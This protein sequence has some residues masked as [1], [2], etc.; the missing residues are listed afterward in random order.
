M[1][2]LQPLRW[3]GADLTPLPHESELSALLRFAWRN[4][5]RVTR[6]RALLNTKCQKATDSSVS[7]SGS[8]ENF[9]AITGWKLVEEHDGV[10]TPSHMIDGLWKHRSF[11]FCPLCLEAAYHS[12]WHQFRPLRYCPVHQ[13]ELRQ[14]CQCCSAKIGPYRISAKL[15]AKPYYCPLCGDP[16]SG[17]NRDIDAH[18][19]FRSHADEL[20]LAFEP[21]DAWLRASGGALTGIVLPVS[22]THRWNFWCRGEDFLRSFVTHF[23][24]LPADCSQGAFKGLAIINWSVKMQDSESYL[25]RDRSWQRDQQR[26]TVEAVYNCTLRLLIHWIG[27]KTGMANDLIA[28][29]A[30]VCSN[31]KYV[32][33]I[34]GTDPRIAALHLMRSHFEDAWTLDPAGRA[35]LFRLPIT[36]I[37][38][39]R[40]RAPRLAWR[41]FF[42]AAYAV[43][44]QSVLKARA[45]GSFAWLGL[46]SGDGRMVPSMN[47]GRY[48]RGLFEG[49]VAF[50]AMEDLPMRPFKPFFCAGGAI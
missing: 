37:P 6:I 5:L 43:F 11:R 17:V 2:S 49:V 27:A 40:G 26:R 46:F 50:P 47:K 19:E 34:S 36:N 35:I 4:A 41:A 20:I 44:L 30:M 1:S 22:L 32:V 38:E 23:H 12:E 45:K 31:R 9:A 24:P 10:L 48:Q 33:K 42:I 29:A 28:Q 39:Y 14:H 3:S 8:R 7:V 13:C 25:H 15:F 16:I 18:V 21:Y